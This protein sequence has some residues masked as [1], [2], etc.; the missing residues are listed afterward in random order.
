MALTVRD[1][2]KF[3]EYLV[4]G[5]RSIRDDFE[6]SCGEAD[7]LVESAVRHGA[8]GARL[9]TISGKRLPAPDPKFGGVI[10]QT[11]PQ[12]TPWWAPRSCRPLVH[13]TCCS[14]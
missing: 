12:S 10:N 14:S 8:W 6:S 7:R 2:P 9:T 13:P 1:Y 11:A 4:E 5:H 3:G